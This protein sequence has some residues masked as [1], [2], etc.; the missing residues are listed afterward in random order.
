[1]GKRARRFVD[2]EVLD[3]NHILAFGV[4]GWYTFDYSLALWANMKRKNGFH[5]VKLAVWQCNGRW[6]VESEGWLVGSG[7]ELNWM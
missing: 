7:G 1:V 3:R 2:R 5:V 6:G 4:S